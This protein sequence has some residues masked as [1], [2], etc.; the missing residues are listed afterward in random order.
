MKNYRRILV[1]ILAGGQSDVLLHRAAELAQAS[2]TQMLVVHVLDS[3]DGIPSDGPA[4]ALPGESAARR[5]PDAMKRLELQ[6]ARYNLAWAEAKVVWGEPKGL[7]TKLVREWAPDLV[8]SCSQ[9]SQDV[10]QDVDTLTVGC[11]SLF[12][13][14]AQTLHSG[15]PRHA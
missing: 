4:G 14:L 6:L 10:V 7:L 1:P 11:R 3:H 9:L 15:V 2:R 13:R 12:R 8:V 5:A